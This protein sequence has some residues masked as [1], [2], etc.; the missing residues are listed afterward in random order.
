MHSYA[1]EQ[2]LIIFL[3]IREWDHE[4]EFKQGC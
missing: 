3:L 2:T 1:K 4:N